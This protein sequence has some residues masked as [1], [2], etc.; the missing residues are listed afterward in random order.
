[1]KKAVPAILKIE[2]IKNQMDQH[3]LRLEQQIVP[4]SRAKDHKGNQ[5]GEVRHWFHGLSWMLKKKVEASFLIEVIQVEMATP[6]GL[7]GIP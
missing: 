2:M 5:H 4:D 7:R 6:S 3:N 1:M